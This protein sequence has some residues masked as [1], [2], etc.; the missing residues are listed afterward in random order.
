MLFERTPGG[1]RDKLRCAAKTLRLDNG[2]E[3][4]AISEIVNYAY[5]RRNSPVIQTG[6]KLFPRH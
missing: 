2:F 4:T 6:W 1:A 5:V 3:A